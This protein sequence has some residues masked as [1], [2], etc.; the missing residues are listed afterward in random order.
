MGMA[1]WALFWANNQTI[2]EVDAAISQPIACFRNRLLKSFHFP[3]EAPIQITKRSESSKKRSG[4][5]SSIW[6]FMPTVART[7]A[8]KA[9]TIEPINNL[10]GKAFTGMAIFIS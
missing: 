9:K 3:V 4:A 8:A 6:D 10:S 7:N 1:C 2:A 5:L